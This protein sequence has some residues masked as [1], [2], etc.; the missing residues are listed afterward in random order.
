VQPIFSDPDSFIS[1]A[2]LEHLGWR[3]GA[4]I[5]ED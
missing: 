2:R 3:A 5:I 4:P 1:V